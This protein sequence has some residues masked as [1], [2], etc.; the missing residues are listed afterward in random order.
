M[1]CRHNLVPGQNIDGQ[2]WWWYW[3]LLSQCNKSSPNLWWKLLNY[4][5]CTHKHK[6]FTGALLA[7]QSSST[8]G[9]LWAAIRYEEGL[10]PKTMSK[11]SYGLQRCPHC[12]QFFQHSDHLRQRSQF[13]ERRKH[14]LEGNRASLSSIPRASALATWDQITPSIGW[15]WLLSGEESHLSGVA[16]LVPPSRPTQI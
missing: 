7:L 6:E 16:A 10:A 3:I 11:Q 5:S 8:I 1:G 13:K 9:Q 2:H 15:C 4:S 12:L 14:T